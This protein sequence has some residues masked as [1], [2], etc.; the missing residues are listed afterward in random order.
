MVKVFILFSVTF[1]FRSEFL[2][3]KVKKVP[4]K[5]FFE[6]AKIQ[7]SFQ[8]IELIEDLYPDNLLFLMANPLTL[9]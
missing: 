4:W 6:M 1:F 7:S 9:K 8:L 3:R 2:E 5:I